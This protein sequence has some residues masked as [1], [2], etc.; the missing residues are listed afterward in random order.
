MS[1]ARLA[2]AATLAAAGFLAWLAA[3]FLSVPGEVREARGGGLPARIAGASD[4]IRLR[5]TLRVAAAAVA[6]PVTAVRLRSRAEQLLEPY[7]LRSSQ[8]ANLLGVLAMLDSRFDRA[9]ELRYAA[10]A[11]AAFSTAVR[12]DPGNEPAKYNLELILTLAHRGARIVGDPNA[13]QSKAKG[14]FRLPEPLTN[15]LKDIGY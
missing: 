8:A 15:D 6:A 12:L 14:A 11:Q 3:G 13:K 5:R 2:A 1:R 4:E 10:V 9:N 7:A